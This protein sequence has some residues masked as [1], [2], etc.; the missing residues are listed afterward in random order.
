[1]YETQARMIMNKCE[2]ETISASPYT[3]SLRTLVSEKHTAPLLYRRVLPLPRKETI[4]GDVE[5]YIPRGFL[6]IEGR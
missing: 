5:R 3:A 1:M 2:M 6:R 4:V